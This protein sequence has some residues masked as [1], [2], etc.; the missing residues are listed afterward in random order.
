MGEL[1]RFECSVSRSQPVLGKW[2]PAQWSSDLDFWRLVF[3]E[4]GRGDAA[5]WPSVFEVRLYL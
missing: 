2:K 4:P 1:D 5:E 3:L